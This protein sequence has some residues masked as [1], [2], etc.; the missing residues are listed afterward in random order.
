MR[1]LALNNNEVHSRN[2]ENIIRIIDIL[3][4]QGSETD[5]DEMSF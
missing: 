2:A 4:S 5:V 3:A 1:I